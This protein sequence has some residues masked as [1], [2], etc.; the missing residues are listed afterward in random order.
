MFLDV[1]KF[2]PPSLYIIIVCYPHSL[3]SRTASNMSSKFSQNCSA[4]LRVMQTY[5][6]THIQFLFMR[7]FTYGECLLVYLMLVIYLFI[8]I[9]ICVSKCRVV[10]TRS[11][12]LSR[13]M[14]VFLLCVC[15]VGFP[16]LFVLVASS[17]WRNY[18]NRNRWARPFPGERINLLRWLIIARQSDIIYLSFNTPATTI[19]GHSFEFL[20]RRARGEWKGKHTEP[21]Y[22]PGPALRLRP[23]KVQP[24]RRS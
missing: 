18:E 5:T 12:Y 19:L 8:F 24:L 16:L 15:Y 2:P 10:Y 11:M 17:P 14:A 3:C 6:H 23:L 22:N 20:I 13:I 21:N 1:S 7:F 4:N 9:S